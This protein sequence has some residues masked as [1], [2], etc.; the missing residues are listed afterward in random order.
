MNAFSTRK[1][2]FSTAKEYFSNRTFLTGIILFSLILLIMIAGFFFLPFDPNEINAEEKFSSFSKTHLLGTDNLGRDVLS[3]IMVGTRISVGLGFSV[4]IFGFAAGLILGA[5][6]GWFGGIPDT[7]LM[8]LVN[9]QMSFPGILLALMLTAV[10]EPR[11]EITFLALCLMSVPRFTRITRSG[12]I[13]YKNSVFVQSA[14]AKG[15][16]NIRIMFVHI[17]PNILNELL[18]TGTTSFSMAILS[19]SGLSYLGLGVQPPNPSFGRM[20]NDA[21]QYI[22]IH[23]SGVIVPLLFLSILVLG[24]NLIGDGISEVNNK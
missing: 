12:F 2:F 23:P 13:K 4:A 3:R 22:F 10:F 6:S 7:I 21:Q 1:R 8:K 15:A 24:I 5:A 14:R 11:I 9:T 18:V 17:F 16:G 19:E 20:L